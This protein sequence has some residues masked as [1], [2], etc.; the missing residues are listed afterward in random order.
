MKRSALVKTAAGT[1]VRPIRKLQLIEPA[2]TS[3]ILCLLP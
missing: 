1:L 2:A 3:V